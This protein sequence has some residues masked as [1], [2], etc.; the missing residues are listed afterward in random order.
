MIEVGCLVYLTEKPYECIRHAALDLGF[1]CGQLSVWD[2]SLYSKENADIIKK[3][4]EEFDFTIT[5]VWCGWSGPEE[6]NYP[7]MYNTI[8]LV[9]AAWRSQRVKEL[10]EGA[11]FAQ[12][13]GVKNIIT[14][15]G[16]MPDNPYDQ[17][18][19]EVVQAA[20]YIC[21]KIAQAGQR[22]LFET[23]EMIPST[24]IQFILEIGEENVGVNFDTA[25]MIINARANSADALNMLVPYVYGMHAKDAVYPQGTSP[26]GKEVKIGTGAA[27]FPVLLR[28]LSENG[29]DGSITIEREI[30]E[31]EQREKDILESKV[32]LENIICEVEKEKCLSKKES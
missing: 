32:F 12:M 1:R 7:N 18:H 27:N 28:I 24:L 14:H 26:K 5:A 2:M 13:L 4:C 20:R 31:V 29:Y 30:K 6:W 11:A 9:P 16:Y 22:F 10:L 17:T 8:G 3:A 23:G 21:K 15:I 25:N 19:V